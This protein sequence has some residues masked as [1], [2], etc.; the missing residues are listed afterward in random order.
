M[1]QTF[2]PRT[3]FE[4]NIGM[5]EK[6]NGFSIGMLHFLHELEANNNR[7]W[8][9]AN[10]A[11]YERDVREPALAFISAMEKPLSRISSQFLAVPKKSGGSLMRVHRDVRF[12]KNKEPY[13]TNVGIHFRHAKGKDVHAPGFYF[14]IEPDES[15]IGAGI[16]H[17]ENPALNA[18]RKQIV[19]RADLWKKIINARSFKTRFE[20]QGD[21]LSRPPQGFDKEHPLIV[22][23]KRKDHIAVA[24]LDTSDLFSANLVKKVSALFK[25]SSSYVEF[26]CSALRLKY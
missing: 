15:F 20:R 19:N 12:S 25:Q 13:K 18:I 8:F 17:P 7:E 26:L 23:L 22:D 10:K 11:R 1:T 24:K 2:S 16:W 6:F 9:E 5:G 4:V 14:H 21:S 3:V